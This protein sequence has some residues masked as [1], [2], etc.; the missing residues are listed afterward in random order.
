MFQLWRCWLAVTQRL[1][2][3]KRCLLLLGM[4]LSLDLMMSLPLLS[5]SELTLLSLTFPLNYPLLCR[6][7]LRIFLASIDFATIEVH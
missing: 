6:R 2:P 7:K 3:S 1:K 4:L 5:L